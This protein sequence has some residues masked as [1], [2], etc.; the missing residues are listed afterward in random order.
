MKLDSFVENELVNIS[1]LKIKIYNKGNNLINYI[2]LNVNLEKVI[3][4]QA[5]KEKGLIY[6]NLI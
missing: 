5:I 4:I 3:I 1:L 6:K 2:D